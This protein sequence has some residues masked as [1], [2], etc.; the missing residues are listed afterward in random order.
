M[1]LLTSNPVSL[2]GFFYDR[3]TDDA[4]VWDRYM[5]G[6]PDQ[7]AQPGEIPDGPND[8]FE[9]DEFA[10]A[11]RAQY[12]EDSQQYI[13]WVL[14]KTYGITGAEHVFPD[15]YLKGACARTAPTL[16]GPYTLVIDVAKGA[17]ANS[18]HSVI[19]VENR[20]THV[21]IYRKITPYKDFVRRVLEEWIPGYQPLYIILDYNSYGLGL[22]TQVV[23]RFDGYQ[24]PNNGGLKTEVILH[25]GSE[26]AERDDKYA[27]RRT[28]AYCRLANRIEHYYCI[29]TTRPG[30]KTLLEELRLIK[31]GHTSVKEKTVL[32]AKTTLPRSPD[33]AD[34]MAMATRVSLTPTTTYRPAKRK[35]IYDTPM[36]YHVRVV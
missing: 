10:I 25:V 3:I 32:E 35:S 17:N 14:G 13:E 18:D 34:C 20:Y 9:T 2:P 5:I 6:R 1:Y 31:R 8:S 11:T 28:E 12:G 30:V 16:E 23:E 4:G 7:Y 33:I 26:R 19:W 27:N 22:G 29:D 36:D 21:A 24:F 15:Y